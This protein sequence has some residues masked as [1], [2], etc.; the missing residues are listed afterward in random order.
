MSFE[1]ID[2]VVLVGNR[3][4]P[5]LDQGTASD[6]EPTLLRAAVSGPRISEEKMNQCYADTVDINE[7]EHEPGLLSTSQR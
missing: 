1:L 5:M 4:E 3:V 2:K 6:D 7:F